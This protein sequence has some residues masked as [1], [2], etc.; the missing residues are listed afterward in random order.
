MVSI[1]KII[2][3]ISCSVVLGLS[4]SNVAAAGHK[5]MET[6]TNMKEG[7]PNMQM[8]RPVPQISSKQFP[9]HEGMETGT[10]MKE[11]GPNMQMN[12]TGK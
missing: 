4:L 8:N 3:V 2:G 9:E 1:P 7:G 11:G 10:N 6:G 12:R 5:N